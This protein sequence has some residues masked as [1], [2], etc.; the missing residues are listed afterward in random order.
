MK[1]NKTYQVCHEQKCHHCAVDKNDIDKLR[2]SAVNLHSV[3]ERLTTSK[4]KVFGGRQRHLTP[5]SLICYM[6]ILK[7][8]LSENT[9]KHMNISDLLKGLGSVTGRI[10]KVSSVTKKLAFISNVV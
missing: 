8:V 7:L 5:F 10:S 9:H 6:V 3:L 2:A 4:V 1:E